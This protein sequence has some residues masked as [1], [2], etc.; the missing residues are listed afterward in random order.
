[1]NGILRLSRTANCDP[2]IDLWLNGRPDVL[3]SIASNWFARMRECGDDVRE[4]MHDGCPVACVK[5]APFGYVNIFSAHVN[6]GFFNGAALDDPAGLLKG[7]GKRM[8][9]VK[10]R[11]P[12]EPNAAALNALIASAYLD[13]KV[14]LGLDQGQLDMA[15]PKSRELG[16]HVYYHKD[17]SVYGR[18]TL[19]DG[20]MTGYWE[21][22]RKDGS[23]MRTGHFAAGEQTGE[24][25]TYTKD[26]RVV[27]VT[28]MKPKATRTTSA[29]RARKR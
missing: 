10:L 21:W 3:H 16:S 27:K 5:D 2:D 25:T 20:V 6:V 26:G 7:T 8:R 24:W 13:I 28:V 29:A 12:A 11:P 9:H 14:Q 17:G 22:Y 1:M 19:R 18:G 4:L 15:T 23:L